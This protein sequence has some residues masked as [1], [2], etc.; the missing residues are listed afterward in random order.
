V[1]DFPPPDRVSITL[2]DLNATDVVNRAEQLQAAS[3]P[4]MTRVVGSE[5]TA[6]SYRFGKSIL[7]FGSLGLA[8]G[9]VGALLSELVVGG[10]HPRFSNASAATAALTGC[11]ALM[12]GLALL[13][14]TGFNSGSRERLVR[15]LGRGLPV[16]LAGG[17]VGGLVAQQIYYPMSREA[18]RHALDVATT[19]S[20]YLSELASALHFPR[21][22]GFALV[23]AAIGGGLGVAA[24][25]AKRA[26]NAV[27]GG[28]VGGFVG[29]YLFDYIGEWANTDSGT[30][31]RLAA[32]TITG[33]LIGLAIGLVDDIR[34]DL[35]V[36]IASGG[37]AGK[38]FVV[39]EQTCTIGRDASSDITLIKDPQI[40]PQH[41]VLRR[42]GGAISIEVIPGASPV[43]VD[44]VVTTAS[45]VTEGSMI[46]VG[47]TVLRIGAR[48]AVMPTFGGR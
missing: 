29:G 9:V 14:W 26:Q 43:R 44:G 33:L 8:G 48:R 25:S 27:A 34:R 45:P 3:A 10:D 37:M 20:Q 19:Y 35:W 38:Q 23:G 46:E 22:V 7:T 42:H 47:A 31:P 17:V 21:G 28:V 1:T 30:L 2:D 15:D 32:L 16:V 12:L 40:A 36:E 24:R 13:A 4:P 6:S 39:W 41:V 11:F 18:R 5:Q